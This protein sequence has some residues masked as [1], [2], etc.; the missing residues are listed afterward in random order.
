MQDLPKFC[1]AA[2]ANDDD[3]DDDDDNLKDGIHLVAAVIINITRSSGIGFSLVKIS[4][5]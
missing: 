5:Q 2:A 1:V 3:D 4:E